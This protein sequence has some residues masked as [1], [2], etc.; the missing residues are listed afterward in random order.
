LTS[1]WTDSF[2]GRFSALKASLATFYVQPNIAYQVSDKWSVG[3]GP[4]FGH[5]SVELIQ[6]IDLSEQPTPTGGTFY[7]AGIP[8]GT[9]FARAT[10]EGSSTAFGAH[11]GVY[12][13]PSAD[14]TVG[15]R[16]LSPLEFEYDGA[17]ASFQQV[18]TNIVLP[19]TPAGSP[20][21]PVCQS[22]PAAC[23]GN[24]N[25][26]ANMDLILASQFAAGGAL[27]SQTVSTK[28]T[29]PAQIQGGFG[30]SGWNNW[31]VSVDYAWTGWKR[32]KELPVNFSNA[33]TPDRVLIEDYNHS[34]AIRVGAQRG[35]TNGA[36]LRLGFSGVASAAPDETVTP[37]LPEQDRSYASLGG[38]Y[39]LTGN[40]T[41][42][43]A[44]LRVMAAGKRGRIHERT[45]R[46]QTAAQLNSGVY[47]LSA[48]V[49]SVSLKANY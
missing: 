12:G 10:L 46:S 41:I 34:S 43:G 17:D 18:N 20:G 23:G 16:F 47:D 33:S 24:A 30:Y 45:A 48:N 19:G 31:L 1:Q 37:L 42:E 38:S 35:F 11:V 36:Q 40:L 14:V 7:Q 13:K 4:V 22:S 26:A 8:R 29:H 5:S 44:Y 15:F 25:G 9:E 3:G 39:P 2:P 21:N 49:F 32:F 27:V 28:I 6:S